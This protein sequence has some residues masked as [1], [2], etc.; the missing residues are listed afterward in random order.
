MQVH[1]LPLDVCVSDQQLL[2]A[3]AIAAAL[4][5]AADESLPPP[6]D[7]LGKSASEVVHLR[8]ARC[9]C[10]YYTASDVIIQDA[11]AACKQVLL[12]QRSPQQQSQSTQEQRT[13]HQVRILG[14]VTLSCLMKLRTPWCR[15]VTNPFV[16]VVRR[17]LS[18]PWATD[19]KFLAVFD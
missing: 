18:G 16:C 4:P 9:K 6:S 3:S 7:T 17:W 12:Q 19:E 2:W 5:A 1:L 15:F 11:D 14:T 13:S 10:Q 8:C